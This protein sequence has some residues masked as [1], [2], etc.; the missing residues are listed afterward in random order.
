MVENQNKLYFLIEIT[1]FLSLHLFEN[2]QEIKSISSVLFPTS[3]TLLNQNIAI[4][5]SDGIHFYTP[6]LEEDTSKKIIFE[7]QFSDGS[8]SEKVAM[9]QFSEE[10]GEYI[11]ILSNEIIYFFE[12]DGT[13]INDV[14]LTDIIDANYYCLIP[15]KKENNY[16]YY[17][18]SYPFEV[19]LTIKQFKFDIDSLTN[20]MIMSKTY[21]IYLQ[22]SDYSYSTPNKI[23]GISCL[24]MSTSTMDHDILTCFYSIYYPTEIQTKSFDPNNNFNELIELFYCDYKGD[25]FPFLFHISAETNQDKKK[26]LL[27][28]V[29]ERSF[30]MTFSFDESFSEHRELFS[31]SSLYLENIYGKARIYYFRQTNEFLFSSSTFKGC[32]NYLMIFNNDFTLKY[33]GLSPIPDGC[34]NTFSHSAFFDGI[35]YNLIIDNGNIFNPKINIFPLKNLTN[36]N[37]N[38]IEEDITDTLENNNPITNRVIKTTIININ[39]KI[40]T[41]VIQN[42]NIKKIKCKNEDF[43]SGKCGGENHP[44]PRKEEMVTKIRDDITNHNIDDILLNVVDGDKED[45]IIKDNRTLYQITTATNQNNK[46][47][48]EISSIKLGDCEKRLRETYNIT[49]ETEL[50]IFKIDNFKGRGQRIPI[51]EYEIYDSSNNQKLDLNICKNMKIKIDI[52]IDIDEKNLHKY[53]LSSDYYTSIC[54]PAKSK[55]NTDIT[56][57]DRLDEFYKENRSLC[58]E[59]CTYNGYDLES[60]NANCEC[61][62]KTEINIDNDEN[63]IDKDKLLNN[64][65]NIKSIINLNV[66]KCFKLIFTKEGIINNYGSYIVLFII[67]FYIISLIYFIYKGYNLFI[68]RIKSIIKSKNNNMRSSKLQIKKDKNFPPKKLKLKSRNSQKKFDESKIDNN[69][70]ES[71]LKIR[72]N[73]YTRSV[74]YK[75]K[76]KRIENLTFKMK[77]ISIYK[78]PNKKI[79]YKDYNDF[80]L[81]LIKYED[82]LVLDKR[83]FLQIYLSLLKTKHIILFTFCNKNDYNLFIIKLSLFFFSFTLYLTINFL[84]FNEETIH[85]IYKDEGKYDFIYQIPKILY[86]TVISS[87][88]NYIIKYLSLSEKNI[89]QL[90][91]ENNN[92]IKINIKIKYIKV[93]KCI[94]IKF[95]FFYIF[96]FLL[97]ILFWFYLSCFCAVYNNSQKFIITDT[98]ISFGLS[99]LYPFMFN[100]LASFLRLLSLSNQKNKRNIIYKI[101]QLI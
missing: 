61:M 38:L 23:V 80:E 82:A 62:I 12:S 75:K 86:S 58:E 7:K 101:S 84:F 81:N 89:L 27:F 54:F 49:P 24:F 30:W 36:E 99:L 94:T 13:K 83:T 45:L 21:P 41:T 91:C 65:L 42:N 56:L 48:H 98:F 88:L 63:I 76:T 85:K 39:Q 25:D 35:Y 79:N 19:G 5:E 22:Y 73:H 60:K 8:E 44:L 55:N 33:Q 43:Y 6:Q 87:I 95:V 4:V 78:K 20:E 34:Y 47:Y 53:N 100:I 18:I 51:N 17:L 77:K 15:F 1:I 9:A 57:T 59:N 93:I 97:L 37:S 11:I 71:N 96:T 92:N 74:K 16:L 66:L 29:N 72:L 2:N 50:L 68:K 26:T 67:F 64:F 52:P 31:D 40:E 32:Q 90:K 70:F 28:G 10:D 69:L 14:N 46:T 3:L